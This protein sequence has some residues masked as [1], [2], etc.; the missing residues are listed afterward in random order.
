MMR[1]PLVVALARVLNLAFFLATAMYGLLSANPFTYE[2][3]ITPHV[4]AALT[5]FAV[6]HPDVH[7]FVL[8]VTALTLAPL[9][10]RSRARAVGWS[11]LAASVLLGV[12]FFLHPLWQLT[13]RSG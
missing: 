12:W 9:L 5:N 2:Q 6:W 11:Y 3:F 8:C 1:R 7:L 13:D 10:E 4:S